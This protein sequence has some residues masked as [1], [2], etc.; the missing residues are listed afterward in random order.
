[1]DIKEK[2]KSYAEGKVLEALTASIEEAYAAGYK[3]GYDDGYIDHRK[4]VINE[5]KNGVEYVDFGIPDKTKWAKDFLRDENG[6]IRY[7]TYDEVSQ[8]NIPTSAQYWDLFNNTEGIGRGADENG[9][10]KI[11]G[12]NGFE[13]SFKV[14]GVVH[15]KY[16]VFWVKTD[17]DTGAYR[18]YAKGVKI[19]KTFMG[20][21]LPV[22][23]VLSEQEKKE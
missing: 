3:E 11:L 18:H 17:S 14:D 21:K 4:E 7:L 8:L 5:L 6:K 23:L 12:R 22:V 1:M 10:C 13:L 19:E 15:G 20:H 2:A 9:I 16:P